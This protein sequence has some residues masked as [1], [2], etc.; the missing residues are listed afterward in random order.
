MIGSLLLAAYDHSGQLG[1]VGNVGTGF[2][3]QMLRDLA[4]Q[5]APLERPTAPT[6]WPVPRADAKDAH[7]VE[8]TLVAE[9]QYRTLTPDGKLRHPSYRGLRPD[10]DPE[11]IQITT[12]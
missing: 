9:V 12:S 4:G 10:R 2:T 8:P 7:W 5:L 11:S 6:A 1:Y 3:E